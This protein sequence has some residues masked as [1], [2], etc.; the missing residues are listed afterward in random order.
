MIL[1]LSLDTPK[2]VL[3]QV[4]QHHPGCRYRRQKSH[5]L[6]VLS[7]TH[8][9][10]PA[11][12]ASYVCFCKETPS[13]AQLS[14][15]A[16]QPASTEIRLGNGIVINARHTCV[17]AGPCSVENEEQ[18]EKTAAFIQGLGIR[19]LRGGAYKPRTSPYVFQGL[20]KEGLRLLEK[21]GKAYG[22]AIVTEVRDATQVDEVLATS[23]IIQIGTKAMYDQGILRACGRSQ[24]PVLLK[25][26]FGSTLQEF[27]QASEYLLVEGNTSVILC[28]RGIR[29]FEN[30]TRFT[31]DLC[32]VAYLKRHSHLPI[33]VDPSHAMGAAYGVPDLARAATAMGIEGL[34][35]EV[36][37]QPEQAL[38]D[39]GQQLD[40]G[41][42]SEVYA[43]LAPVA[44]AVG[45]SLA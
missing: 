21:V 11:E 19:L 13:N 17:V 22:L 42:F 1:H 2:Q 30:K 4:V 39:S 27:L 3:Q 25:R 15:R 34:L 24:K 45:R 23:D 5:Y 7:A 26:G 20:G 12:L 33:F 31:L 9:H 35:I 32:G 14:L 37:P 40:F 6:M 10:P 28:E 18:L 38:S 41:A 43:S 36:H 44:E 29:S 8:Q 16:Y